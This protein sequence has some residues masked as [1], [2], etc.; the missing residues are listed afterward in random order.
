VSTGS[1]SNFIKS[2]GGPQG[3]SFQVTFSPDLVTTTYGDGV[4]V[5]PFKTDPSTEYIKDPV[6]AIFQCVGSPD[7]FPYQNCKRGSGTTGLYELAKAITFQYDNGVDIRWEQGTLFDYYFPTE[8][9]VEFNL[10][11]WRPNSAMVS[12]LPG[13]EPFR[14]REVA[15]RFNERGFQQ[16][17]D[18]PTPAPILGVGMALRF[19]RRLRKRIKASA[20]RPLARKA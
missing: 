14:T 1:V 13:Q 20:T 15:F 8:F 7:W 16:L 12:G 2:V 19:S 17:I 6:L 4:F 18:I 10:S 3:S 5:P 11:R 9:N